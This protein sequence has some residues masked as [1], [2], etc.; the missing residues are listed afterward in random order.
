MGTDVSS[1]DTTGLIPFIDKTY[2]DFNYGDTARGERVID[3][4]YAT[5][6]LYVSHTFWR[7]PTM[8]C[9]TVTALGSG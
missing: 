3:M 6:T 8:L 4:Q 1:A 2:F 9:R 5:S 7:S